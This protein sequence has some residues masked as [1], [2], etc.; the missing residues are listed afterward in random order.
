MAL[1]R[2][3]KC[4]GSLSYD[5]LLANTDTNIGKGIRSSYVTGRLAE[6]TWD[7]VF[8]GQPAQL[9][10][11]DHG[12]E[13]QI[14]G[15]GERG[16]FFAE[17]LE[18]VGGSSMEAKG[19]LWKWDAAL[20]LIPIKYVEKRMEMIHRWCEDIGDGACLGSAATDQDKPDK[21]DET[22]EEE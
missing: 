21:E 10:Y 14:A 8:D 11:L 19:N 9:G 16:D 6:W 4:Q 12:Q 7:A 22:K 20:D 13:E 1:A 3:P 17:L 18:Y 5:W 2:V 15:G